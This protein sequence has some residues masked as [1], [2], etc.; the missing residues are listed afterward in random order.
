MILGISAFYHDSAAALVDDDGAIIAAAQEERFTRK[1][2][3]PG[4][5][6]KA[7][8]YCLEEAKISMSDIDNVTFYDKPFLKFERLLET[9]L[10]FAPRGFSSFNRAIPV[11]LKEKLFQK[12]FL[13]KEFRKFDSGFDWQNKLLFAEHHRLGDPVGFR[14]RNGLA[15]RDRAEKQP[16][17]VKNND[18][19]SVGWYGR[20]GVVGECGRSSTHLAGGG[21]D[22]SGPSSSVSV[23]ASRL[24]G[25]ASEVTPV[26]VHL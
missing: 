9:Y 1:K 13:R 21:R 6:R 25:N 19:F 20:A 17:A 24:L 15:P 11:W 18:G 7:I 23:D 4:F 8:E 22:P 14:P 5:P 16:N 12:D 10:S 2:H 3:D 26:L